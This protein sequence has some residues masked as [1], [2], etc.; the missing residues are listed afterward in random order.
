MYLS[1][2][3]LAPVEKHVAKLKTPF[4]NHDLSSHTHTYFQ[5]IRWALP[6]VAPVGWRESFFSS[7]ALLYRLRSDFTTLLRFITLV[8]IAD[9]LLTHVLAFRTTEVRRALNTFVPRFRYGFDKSVRQEGGGNPS[10]QSVSRVK[11]PSELTEL[12]QIQR[13]DDPAESLFSA[14]TVANHTCQADVPGGTLAW[15]K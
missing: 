6:G 2:T 11:C 8:L 5:A 13:S 15:C 10:I 14:V 4:R 1:L 7:L 12:T 3:S 9:L